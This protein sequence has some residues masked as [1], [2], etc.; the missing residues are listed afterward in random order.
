MIDCEKQKFDTKISK[1]RYATI[2]KNQNFYNEVISQLEQADSHMR[3]VISQA[4]DLLGRV[5]Q[6]H[7]DMENKSSQIVSQMIDESVAV[8]VTS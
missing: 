2:V 8:D 4:T 6:V 3:N 7:S 1:S 5:V